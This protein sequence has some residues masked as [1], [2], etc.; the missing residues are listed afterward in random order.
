[1]SAALKNKPSLAVF[2][3]EV[4]YC[5]GLDLNGAG[6]FSLLHHMARKGDDCADSLSA[7]LAI[8]M[9][10]GRWKKSSCFYFSNAMELRYLGCCGNRENVPHLSKLPAYL[11][12]TVFFKIYSILF[13]ANLWRSKKFYFYLC[14]HFP[15][16]PVLALALSAP[17]CAVPKESCPF[18]ELPWTKGVP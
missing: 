1:M 13:R 9:A 10:G 6:G 4:F 18:T 11:S 2:L 17:T 3:A 14:N 8:R 15:E 5:S 16:P 7:L 12:S